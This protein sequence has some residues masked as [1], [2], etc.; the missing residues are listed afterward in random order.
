MKGGLAA[1]AV[2]AVVVGVARACCA[3]AFVAEYGAVASSP[4]GLTEMV[5]AIAI[6]PTSKQ[7]ATT[8]LVMSPAGNTTTRQVA[9]GGQRYQIGGSGASETC[10]T[11]SAAQPGVM[12]GICAG[13]SS[14]AT[15]PSSMCFPEAEAASRIYDRDIQAYRGFFWGLLEERLVL[16]LST[17]TPINILAVNNGTG[18]QPLTYNMWMGPQL[19]TPSA[20]YFSLPAA[21]SNAKAC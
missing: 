5:M 4:S 11:L 15:Q 6:D 7:G 17:C 12:P 10:C 9:T 14:C 3:P 2:A 19:G 13:P 1:L 18:A 16:D 8:T 21:C 20:S